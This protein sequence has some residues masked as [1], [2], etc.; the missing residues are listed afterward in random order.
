V[1]AHFH[2]ISTPGGSSSDGFLFADPDF[3]YSSLMV[4]VALPG[5]VFEIWAWD[6]GQTEDKR[7]HCYKV[8]LK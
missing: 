6:M 8:S 4:T 2:H 7:L 3:L 1:H 5:L